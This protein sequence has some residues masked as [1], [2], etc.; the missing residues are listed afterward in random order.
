MPDGG[1]YEYPWKDNKINELGEWEDDT[2]TTLADRIGRIWIWRN[3]WLKLY[4]H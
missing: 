4:L 1:E 2:E 3:G